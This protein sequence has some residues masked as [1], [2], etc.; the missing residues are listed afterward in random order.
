MKISQKIVEF[1]QSSSGSDSDG[2]Q[3]IMYSFEYYP[4]K[5]D[6]ATE[7]LIERIDR[8]AVLNPL[9][10]DITWGAGGSTSDLTLDITKH[11]Q[12]FT[13]LD[14]MMH[15]TCTNMTRDLIDHAL[16]KCHEFGVRNIL[17]LRGDPPHGQ[18]KW[19]STEGGFEYASDLVA[20]IK[21]KYGDHFC[22]AVAGY[23]ETHSEAESAEKTTVLTSDSRIEWHSFSSK[24][25]AF[26][27]NLKARNFPPAYL[28]MGSMSGQI[29]GSPREA[30]VTASH[31]PSA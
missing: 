14:C 23:P 19:T 2:A 27:F 7:N 28:I 20:Y 11:I 5:T 29:S 18:E 17:A 6:V 24:N 21:E 31:C 4:P 9:W 16:A 26:V 15:L 13:G 22:I 30:R 10:V 1:E 8:M 3:K 12:T 25:Q